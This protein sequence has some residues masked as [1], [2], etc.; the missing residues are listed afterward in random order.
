MEY[1]A[2]Q[3]VEEDRPLWNVV[4]TFDGSPQVNYFGLDYY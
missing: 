2:N 4:K 3:I 1:G